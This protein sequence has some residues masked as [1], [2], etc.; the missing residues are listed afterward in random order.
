LKTASWIKHILFVA[1]SFLLIQNLKF[2]DAKGYA[3]LSEELIN[4]IKKQ[5]KISMD[6][7]TISRIEID[8]AFA[9]TTYKDLKSFMDT[10]FKDQTF[11]D[12]SNTP[13]LYFYL[14]RQVPS[15]FNQYLQNTVTDY[16]QQENIQLLEQIKPPV[17]LF[18]WVP[19]TWWDAPDGV[20]NPLRYTYLTNY[21]YA[22]YKPYTT[23]NRHS[24]W[25][26]KDIALN[27]TKAPAVDSAETFAIRTYSLK[28]LAYLLG[29]GKQG[30]STLIQ[31]WERQAAMT[32]HTAITNSISRNK[33]VMLEAI[34]TN[35][36]PEPVK[37]V[38]N[39]SEKGNVKG[40][41]DFEVT[42]GTQQA[43]YVIPISSQ[44]NWHAFQP[45]KISSNIL[46]LPGIQIE[47]LKLVYITE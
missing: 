17:T 38:F 1:A 35:P 10:H 39:Y 5:D 36:H 41:Y 8:S 30:T 42:A 14:Q 22:N 7:K 27:N 23:L 40:A 46:E 25:L 20:P 3:P 37:M 32:A 18:S 26:R 4:Q 31:T 12:F 6:Q 34:I 43:K 33:I 47:N 16:L 21:I 9:D 29:K 45:D 28:K 44:Y 2:P 19:S 13:M 24:V 11:I 15:Y